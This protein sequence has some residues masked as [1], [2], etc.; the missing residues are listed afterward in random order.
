MSISNPR[1]DL[2]TAQIRVRPARSR[3]P[4]SEH[5]RGG[6]KSLPPRSRVHRPKRLTQWE[7]HSHSITFREIPID[8]RRTR[9]LRN[10]S[11]PTSFHSSE[12]VTLTQ[13]RL[14]LRLGCIPKFDANSSGTSLAALKFP[15]GSRRA[16]GFAPI[17]FAAN[18]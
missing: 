6:G 7:S 10:R 4:R 5:E 2:T 14:S 17:K 12:C 3:M 13:A 8:H 18:S 9:H 1:I 16:L 15:A 11:S